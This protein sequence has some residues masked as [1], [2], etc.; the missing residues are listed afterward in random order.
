M[1]TDTGPPIELGPPDIIGSQAT[2]WRDKPAPELLAQF[3]AH[4]GY[5]LIHMPGVHAFWS[6]WTVSIASLRDLQGVP[7]ATVK[8]P[9]ATH[10]ILAFAVDPD[11]KPIAE[12][13]TQGPDAV[14]R[15]LMEP[16]DLVHQ[17]ALD[18]DERA[19]DLGELFVRACCDGRTAPDSD[20]RQ[21]N[22]QLIDACVKRMRSAS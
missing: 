3:P 10:E 6:F 2:A 8:V 20:F 17:F 14:G 15:K 21:A 12:W 4:V 16:V 13:W 5:W 11:W 19:R 22:I 9:G 7:Q 18:D 1:T